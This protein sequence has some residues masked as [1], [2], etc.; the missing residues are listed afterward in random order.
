MNTQRLHHVLKQRRKAMMHADRSLVG[1]VIKRKRRERKRTQELISKGV[2]SV[3]YLSK[4]ENNKMMP[5]D[6]VIKELSRRL[7]I[8]IDV[9]MAGGDGVKL[10][11]EALQ[12]YYA[13]QVD[14]LENIET[15][16]NISNHHLLKNVVALM[17]H[18]LVKR[19]EQADALCRG[20]ELSVPNMDDMTC[21]VYLL[22]AAT[23]A[24][25]KHRPVESYQLLR[26]LRSSFKALSAEVA[27][28]ASD[29]MA[30]VCA[31]LKRDHGASTA[32]RDALQ[33]YDAMAK[34]PRTL[35]RKLKGLLVRVDDHPDEVASALRVLAY[36]AH[37]L[38]NENLF[39]YVHAKTLQRQG[40]Y[41]EAK[42]VLERLNRRQQ[43][44]W[45]FRGTLL[46]AEMLRTE[47][48]SFTPLTEVFSTRQAKRV[49]LAESVAFEVMRIE[50]G[51][52]RADY[53]KSVA[54][55]LAYEQFDLT[56][57]R[58]YTDMLAQYAT[59]QRRYK[60]AV[61]H[62]RRTHKRMRMMRD[63]LKAMP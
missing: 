1:D 33:R 19:N 32:H 18:A 31:W 34:T 45:Y 8:D 48:Q 11:E 61:A 3:S 30:D 23:V 47:G 25:R 10:L 35:A 21:Q 28:L 29:I 38:T 13:G 7:D 39:R 42:H 41:T 36:D 57:M 52:E 55:P 53:V 37:V 15:E 17:R 43:D 27:V 6:Y 2:C 58:A 26:T 54:L 22:L 60:E 50:D 40:S 24:K 14:A 4:I 20:L 56:R 12:Y 5:S 9:Y 49:A 59:E 16:V 46:F 63:A 44:A 51:D 62:D